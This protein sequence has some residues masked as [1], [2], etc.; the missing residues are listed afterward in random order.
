[1]RATA[2]STLVVVRIERVWHVL[3][4]AEDGLDALKDAEEVL[5]RGGCLV[6][7]SILILFLLVIVIKGLMA[8]RTRARGL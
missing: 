5:G 2:G 6:P 8:T 3:V 1:M 7:Q 4:A